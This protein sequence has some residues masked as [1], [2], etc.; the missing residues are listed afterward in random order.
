M[1]TR[2]FQP[3]TSKAP[4]APYAFYGAGFHSGM[5][6]DQM[7]LEGGVW[8][9][10]N[11]SL[12]EPYMVSPD[13]KGGWSAAKDRPADTRPPS[14]LMAQY[15]PDVPIK[16]LGERMA[17]FRGGTG[18]TIEWPGI[19]PMWFDYRNPVS[20]RVPEH[21]TPVCVPCDVRPDLALSAHGYLAPP[22]GPEPDP[23]VQE[24]HRRGRR[25]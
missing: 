5:Y 8:R 22:T 16:A 4:A 25:R 9:F 6:H 1:R 14:V 21:Y 12:D 17:H 3:R 15:P 19:L 7:V 10:W 23:G 13:W 11:L 24:A 2:L 20:G 18:A